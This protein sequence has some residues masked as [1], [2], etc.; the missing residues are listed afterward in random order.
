MMAKGIIRLWKR[1]EL[2]V[3]RVNDSK[4]NRLYKLAGVI[5]N[6][7][8]FLGSSSLEGTKG[9][10]TKADLLRKMSMHSYLEPVFVSLH[11]YT[12]V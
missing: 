4:H 12:L 5:I 7:R 10:L 3:K 11:V 6:E 1:R 2:S 9:N 8:S